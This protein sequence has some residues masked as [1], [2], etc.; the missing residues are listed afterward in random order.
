MDKLKRDRKTWKEW[1]DLAYFKVNKIHKKKKKKMKL[2]LSRHTQ[3]ATFVC[4]RAEI[5]KLDQYREGGDFSRLS[6]NIFCKEM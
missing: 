2:K 1:G 4:R 6:K 5:L 3:T